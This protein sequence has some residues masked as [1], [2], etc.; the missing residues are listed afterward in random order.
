[1]ISNDAASPVYVADLTSVSMLG[2]DWELS[3]GA[4]TFS[5]T[6][7]V[8]IEVSTDGASYSLVDT[9]ALTTVDTQFMVSLG[10]AL[11]GADQV[12]VRLGLD[13]A[14]GAPIIDNVALS[15]VT[16]AVPEPGTALLILAGLAGLGA[17][18]RRR[19]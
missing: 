16:A 14:S 17:I 12:F 4:N 10:A 8:P 15:A 7:S 11:D 5:G 2:E 19:S 3:L 9:L 18:G 6:A 1:M 13:A